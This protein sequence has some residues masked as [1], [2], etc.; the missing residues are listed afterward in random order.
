MLVELGAD[1]CPK[2][3]Q[4]YADAVD[5]LK[6]LVGIN[7]KVIQDLHAIHKAFPCSLL[8]YIDLREFVSNFIPKYWF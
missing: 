2:L 5:R 4:N 7:P 3:F 6:T 1:D 8:I